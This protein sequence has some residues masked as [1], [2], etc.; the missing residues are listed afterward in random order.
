M[1]KNSIGKGMGF[2]AILERCGPGSENLLEFGSIVEKTQCLSDFL[3]M[4]DAVL[5]LNFRLN[6]WLMGKPNLI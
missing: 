2:G 5:I 4:R 1:V 3:L 6:G